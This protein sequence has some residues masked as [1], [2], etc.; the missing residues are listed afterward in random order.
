MKI[1]LDANI[2]FAALIKDSKTTE[3][4]FDQRLKLYLPDF[5]LQEFE[6]YEKEL[7][8]K[9]KRTKQEFNEILE[10]IKKIVKIISK[11]E[12]SDKIIEAS[13]ICPDKYDVDYFALALK[14]NAPIWSNDKKLK[15]QEKVKIYSTQEIIEVLKD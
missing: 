10:I 9:T 12:F 15:K 14:L 2:L 5:V 1:I 13:K 4:L 6:K 8:E 7:L 3:L 11:Q